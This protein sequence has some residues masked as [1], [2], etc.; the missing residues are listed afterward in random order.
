M[1]LDLYRIE[2]DGQTVLQADNLVYVINPDAFD[3]W[4]AYEIKIR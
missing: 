2:T 4:G 3:I 1:L